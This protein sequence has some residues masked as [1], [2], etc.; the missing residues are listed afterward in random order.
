MNLY[1]IPFLNGYKSLIGGYGLLILGL[2]GVLVTGADFLTAVG[3]CLVGTISLE[4]C[5]QETQATFVSLLAAFKGLSDIGLA[6]KIEKS[7]NGG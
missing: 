3:N 1:N 7:S 5:M 2:A 6:H 4:L